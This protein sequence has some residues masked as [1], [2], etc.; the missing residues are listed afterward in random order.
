MGRAGNVGARIAL[1]LDVLEEQ[2]CTTRQRINAQHWLPLY[3]VNGDYTL[4]PLSLSNYTVL[5]I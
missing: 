4:Q 5:L 1:S 3:T 2:A